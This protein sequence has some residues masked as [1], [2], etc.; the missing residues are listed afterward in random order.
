MNIGQV[1]THL[2]TELKAVFS[3]DEARE[4]AF[5]LLEHH[6]QI[7]RAKVMVQFNIEIPDNS[8]PPLALAMEDL[9]ANK[10]IQYVLGKTLFMESEFIVNK[11][12]LIPRPETEELVQSIINELRTI[13]IDINFPIKVLDI[14]TG[15]GCIAIALKN[16]FPDMV[17]FGLDN[18]DEAL[19]VARLN[20]QNLRADVVFCEA[21]ILDF[22][23]LDGL[24]DFD[25]IISN[26][27]YVLEK[28]KKAMQKNVLEYEPAAALFVPDNQP[29]LYYEA[30]ADYAE[31][32]LRPGGYIFLEI[33]ESYGEEVK[34]LYLKHGFKDVE[35]LKDLFGKD[36]FLH[37][38][39]N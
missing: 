30:I 15:S 2:L 11:H 33:N 21:D 25:V 1:Y 8:L 13:V 39:S 3:Y 31:H 19:E 24:P 38:K 10:P 14:G 7:T 9:L 35:I 5:R 4:M 27:P 22:Q 6:L 16:Y 12:V 29:L 20:A 18:S 37:C 28:E 26:P 23:T 36:R 34:S 17:V 32:K